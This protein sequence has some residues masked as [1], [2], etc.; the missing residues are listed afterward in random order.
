MK[1]IRAC[2]PLLLFFSLEALAFDYQLCSSSCA[3][4]DSSCTPCP[5]YKSPSSSL[6]PRTRTRKPEPEKAKNETTQKNCST[7]PVTCVPGFEWSATACACVAHDSPAPYDQELNAALQKCE[8]DNEK[9][10]IA[11]DQDQDSGIQGAQTS[12]SNFAVGAGARMGITNACSSLGALLTGANAA[13]L[14][15]SQNCS[16][17]QKSCL[18]S[19]KQ[20]ISMTGALGSAQAEASY[21]N[22]KLMDAKINQATQ[23]IA[24][25]KSTAQ[26]AANCV[27]QTDTAMADFCQQNPKALGCESVPTDCSNPQIAASN[28]ICI[29]KA[30]P[31]AAHCSGLQAKAGDFDS[32][33]SY[34]MASTTITK[35]SKG[36]GSDLD[37]M[38]GDDGY[39][40][41]GM[42]PSGGRA[43]DVGGAKGGRPL[44]GGSDGGLGGSGSPAGSASKGG[45]AAVNAGFRGG[46]GGSSGSYGGGGGANPG[47]AYASEKQVEKSGPNLRDFL[48]N[49]K[50]DPKS[51]NRGL[52]G[53][54]GPDGIT[55]PHS[56]I[57][58]KIQNRYQVQ[59]SKEKLIP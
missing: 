16:S 38:L 6:Q 1:V 51:A 25:I 29:C 13:V 19:C 34:D 40:G 52:A 20:A 11:C 54:S 53:I 36:G 44:M 35:S 12:L 18:A 17:S 7:S 5:E 32:G 43:D 39:Q 33:G 59:I 2:V 4:G 21:D 24:N 41:N 37:G 22:C 58:K 55:G 50:F 26:N 57:W 28:S 46:G 45:P 9:A 47:Q 48:P 42:S 8:T 10:R 30:N 27:E 14:Y 31:N 49:G 3:P 56:D 23:A 15:F